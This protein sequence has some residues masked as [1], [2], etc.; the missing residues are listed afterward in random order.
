MGEKES[1]LVSPLYT[2]P[3]SFSRHA[4]YLPLKKGRKFPGLWWRPYRPPARPH[5]VLSRGLSVNTCTH[6]REWVL[7]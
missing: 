3:T 2:D 6:C 1:F 7:L 5:D 4:F